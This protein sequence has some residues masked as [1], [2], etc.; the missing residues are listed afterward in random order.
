MRVERAI[1]SVLIVDDDDALLRALERGAR[2]RCR[3]LV[4]ST[5]RQALDVAR[6]ERPDLAVVDLRLGE[7]GSGLELVRELRAA[8]PALM[9]ALSSAYLS[10]PTTLE[11][12][13]AG[14][15]TVLA[16]PMTL[17]EIVARVEMRAMEA[18]DLEAAPT[19]AA[20]EWNYIERVVS[21]TG[22]NLSAAARIL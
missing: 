14:A 13:R 7:A 19:L 6:T 17:G 10:I 12:I 20:I 15:D 9:I 11:A 4:A 2:G 8:L 3:V 16:K 22:R 1:R 21:D 18:E 5:A